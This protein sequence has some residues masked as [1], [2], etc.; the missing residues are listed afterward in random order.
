MTQWSAL[1]FISMLA[2]YHTHTTWSD[3]KS[4]LDDLLRAASS[5]GISEIGI[6]D[7]LVL[8]PQ[9]AP[10]RWSMKA[11]DLESYIRA[12]RAAADD[13]PL[14]VRLGVEADW[15]PEMSTVI[16]QTFARANFD[17]VIGSVHYVDDFPIDGN[18]HRW[19]QLSQN[20]VD[21][22]HRAYW[23]RIREMAES[24]LYD[25]AAH[26]DLPKKF[27]YRPRQEPLDAIES[28][29]DALAEAEMVVEV[30]TAGW[31]KPCAEA[32]PGADILRG[33]HERGIA[34]TISSDAHRPEDLLRDFGRAAELLAGVGFTEVARFGPGGE[35]SF[36]PLDA[37]IPTPERT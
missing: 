18:P 26:L 22:V 6:S 27:G 28:A 13:S 34:V 1:C 7:H 11:H 25:L 8:H 3:G 2:N 30:N 14:A 35:R 33:C 32:Y 31:H 9:G 17:Y 24:G 19:K 5:Q 12:I 21:H 23:G 15:F 4:T 37:A 36:E 16:A 10:P 29:L 20:D